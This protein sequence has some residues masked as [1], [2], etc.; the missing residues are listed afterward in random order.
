MNI[1]PPVRTGGLLLGHPW[2]AADTY[3][4]RPPASPGCAIGI[5]LTGGPSSSKQVQREVLP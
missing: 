1:D 4:R 5:S 2:P 3:H